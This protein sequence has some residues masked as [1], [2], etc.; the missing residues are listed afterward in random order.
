AS[1]LRH[2]VL[3]ELSPEQRACDTCRDNWHIERGRVLYLIDLT[4]DN[5]LVQ[6]ALYKYG[7]EDNYPSLI[8]YYKTVTG[9]WG[10]A[11]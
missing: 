4:L 6:K 9:I 3:D 8:Y 7:W 2:L 10:P 5:K 11:I 1:L